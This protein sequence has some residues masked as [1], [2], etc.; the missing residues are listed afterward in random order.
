MKLTGIAILIMAAT[1]HA[2]HAL[3]QLVS[4]LQSKY[5]FLDGLKASFTQSYQ[6]RRFS[7]KIT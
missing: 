6:C 3:D 5:V 4:K 2:D 1:V 7:D